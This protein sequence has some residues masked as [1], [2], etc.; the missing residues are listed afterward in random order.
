MLCNSLGSLV[1]GSGDACGQKRSAQ[2]HSAHGATDTGIHD[3]IFD[4]A[5]VKETIGYGDRECLQC[6]LIRDPDRAGLC[7]AMVSYTRNQIEAAKRD[8]YAA[9]IFW[10]GKQNT[11]AGQ[12]QCEPGMNRV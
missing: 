2:Y 8:N 4:T 9:A 5:P 10:E 6:T 12:L 1:S 3:A 7:R 11:V